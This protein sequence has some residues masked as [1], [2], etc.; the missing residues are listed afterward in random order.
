M[1]A[2]SYMKVNQKVAEGML[3]Y[4]DSSHP[5]FGLEHLAEHATSANDGFQCRAQ[6]EKCFCEHRLELETGDETNLG[7]DRPV[8]IVHLRLEGIEHLLS[9]SEVDLVA[10]RQEILEQVARISVI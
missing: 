7:P 6:R 8:E 9:Q 5:V 4:E 3:I 10:L 2:S 1:S